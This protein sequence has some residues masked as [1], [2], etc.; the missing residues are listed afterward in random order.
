LARRTG[1][2]NF[3]QTEIEYLRVLPFGDKNVC[4]LYVA[5]NDTR[6]MRG[7]QRI[8][9]LNGQRQQGFSV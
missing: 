6:S 3:R 8:S 1:N 5:V 2:A 4:R 7:I 9:D